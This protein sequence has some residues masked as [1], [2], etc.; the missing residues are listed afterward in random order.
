MKDDSANRRV[1]DKLGAR[2]VA[3]AVVVA[4]ILVTALRLFVVTPY[5]VGGHAMEETLLA[6]DWVLV[7]RL[8]YNFGEPAPGDVICFESP[9]GGGEVFFGRVIAREGQTV[10]IRGGAVYLDGAAEPLAEPYLSRPGTDSYGPVVVPRG[11]LF[12]MGDNRGVARDSRIWGP[13][14]VE[15][16]IGKALLVYFSHD[17][18]ALSLWPVPEAAVRWE[19]MGDTIE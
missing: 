2:R 7:S 19:R 10:E 11:R 1:A 8:A 9:G 17:P 16:V 15:L 12:V 6:G 5:R 3:G 13:L 4:F 18:Y 14:P